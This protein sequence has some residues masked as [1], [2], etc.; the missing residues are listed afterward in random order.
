MNG[1]FWFS[2]ESITESR[3]SRRVTSLFIPSK[4]VVIMGHITGFHLP[5]ILTLPGARA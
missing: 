2:R 1:T 4:I 3:G 5:M